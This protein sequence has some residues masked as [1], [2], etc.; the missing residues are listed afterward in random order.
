MCVRF[1][2][3]THPGRILRVRRIYVVTFGRDPSVRFYTDDAAAIEQRRARNGG[4]RR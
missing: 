1:V 2:P 4:T 3:L